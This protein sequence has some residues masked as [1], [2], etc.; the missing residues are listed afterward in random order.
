M[1]R[2]RPSRPLLK[3]AAVFALGAAALA[4][5][6]APGAASAATSSAVAYTALGPRVAGAYTTS[7]GLVVG[8]RTVTLHSL[9]GPVGA[10]QAPVGWVGR[11]GRQLLTA[12]DDPKV[13]SRSW[14]AV[15]DTVRDRRLAKY[16][17][18]DCDLGVA[19]DSPGV[20]GGFTRGRNNSTGTITR[21]DSL[22][23]RVST[24]AITGLPRTA[25]GITE[26]AVVT[27]AAVRS[28][29]L[30]LF[31]PDP[32]G[33]SAYGGPDQVWTVGWNGVARRVRVES[34]NVGLG[35]PVLS[36]D[37]RHLAYVA[38][39]RAGVC[40]ESFVPHVLDLATGRATSPAIPRGLRGS[41]EIFASNLRFQGTSNLVFSWEN[42]GPNGSWA[43]DCP[44]SKRIVPNVYYWRAGHPV[45]RIA[46]RS[47]DARTL[48]DHSSLTE[49]FVAPGKDG[50][51]WTRLHLRGRVVGPAALE[52]TP[53]FV[54]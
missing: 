48:P 53:L 20:I 3:S 26:T 16:A 4:P 11:T 29:G 33:T 51:G 9:P 42:A 2:F 35:W 19:A 28:S 1:T 7:V 43:S 14:Y 38:G 6:A 24:V 23:R 13:P 47:I 49:P 17:C 22:L 18:R 36:S 39:S 37:G 54:R 44:G 10:N 21:Y 52:Y 45:Q 46:A 34:A 15:I 41:A 27:L 8:G 31:V 40:A 25:H 30:V 50:L 5:L 12:S 32:R